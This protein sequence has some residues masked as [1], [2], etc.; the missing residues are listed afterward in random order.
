MRDQVRDALCKSQAAQEAFDAAVSKV[1]QE[2]KQTKKTAAS[3]LELKDNQDTQVGG[4]EQDEQ[5][6]EV[7]QD[8]QAGGVEQDQEVVSEQVAEPDKV[9]LVRIVAERSELAKL[10]GKVCQ[11]ISRG[12]AR[13]SSG[14][15]RRAEHL[16]DSL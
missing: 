7:K 5:A 4:E 2:T 1:E 13:L 6:G 8:E 11:V 10:Y 15:S 9:E 12:V 3:A 14:A 16:G